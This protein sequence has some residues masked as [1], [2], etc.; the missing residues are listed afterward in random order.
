MESSQNKLALAKQLFDAGVIQ[1]GTFTLKSGMQ[2]PIYVDMRRIISYPKL[3]HHLVDQLAQHVQESAF[4]LLCGVPYAALPLAAGIALQNAVPMIMPRKEIKMHG[5]KRSIEG[6]YAKGQTAIII[7][8]VVTS[9]GSILEIVSR[10]KEEQL[11]VHDAWVVIDR[12]QGAK[13]KLA[14]HGITIYALY[15]LSEITDALFAQGIIDA[16]TITNV[17]TFISQNQC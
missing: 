11:R 17:S 5:T 3:L 7:E 1:F 15:T 14:R 12:E 4:D 16:T 10:L 9:G 6:V 2:S 8:D 13:E